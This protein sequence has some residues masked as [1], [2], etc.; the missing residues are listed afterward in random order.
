MARRQ[1]LLASHL[2][3]LSRL[4]VR[5]D[6]IL[7][8][9]SLLSLP[10]PR[11]RFAVMLILPLCFNVLTWLVRRPISNGWA[12]FF[13][14]WMVK[15]DLAGS[16]S[17]S[18]I[19]PRVLDLSLAY[20]H[21]PSEAPNVLM[22][23]LTLSITLFMMMLSLHVPDRLLPLRYLLRF[24][25]FVQLTALVFFAIAPGAFPYT[26]SD[27]IRSVLN[28]AV[29][30]VMMVPWVHALIY[31]IFDFSVLQ[32]AALTLMTLCFLL[33]ALPFQVM[34][35]AYL[36]VKGSLLVMPLLYFVFGIWLLMVACVALYGW[37]MSWHRQPVDPDYAEKNTPR[38]L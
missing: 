4:G 36:L 24:G 16:V 7:L 6:R 9:R 13:E 29:W 34:V 23:W 11:S 1:Y 35:H 20:L 10:F 5:G 15:L 18:P 37:A 30:L 21:L 31:Y 14:F 22:W 17:M 19:G 3:W 26:I 2:A 38:P 25:L 28:S 33:A 8:H 27:Y 32:K 12:A